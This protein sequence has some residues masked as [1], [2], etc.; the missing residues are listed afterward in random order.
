[1]IF[2]VF[3]LG[4]P[5]PETHESRETGV[6]VYGG[7]RATPFLAVE[8][9]YANL[10]EFAFHVR[11]SSQCEGMP[12]GMN[13][14]AVV[15]PGAQGQISVEGWSLS[16]VATLPLADRLELGGRLGLFRSTVTL[17]GYESGLDSFLLDLTTPHD[18]PAPCWASSCAIAWRPRSALAWAGSG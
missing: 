7:F 1:M 5:V 18:K 17:E 4:Y 2:R 11:E 9:G 8:A 10:G 14:L 13:C 3:C 15:I 12:P 16:A 6:T